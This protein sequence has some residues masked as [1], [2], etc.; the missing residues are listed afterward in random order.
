MPG[1]TS[2][3]P[4][5][6]STRSSQERNSQRTS[7]PARTSQTEGE[8]PAHEGP[9]GFRLDPAPLTRPQDTEHEETQAGRRENRADEIESW[10]LLHGRIGDL[11]REEQDHG[12]DQHLSGEDPAP[13][14]VRRAETAD[15]RPDGDGDR[16]C[17]RH[18][19]VGGG[20][21][22]S[23]EVPGHKGDDGGHDQRG[24]HALEKRPAEQEHG[25]ARRDR[26]RER[27]ASVD[28]AADREGP[29]PADQRPDLGARDHEGGHHERVGGDR[30]LDSRD[31]RADV[32]CHGGDRD[33]HDRAV[34]RHQEL[35]RRERQQDEHAPRRRGGS[36]GNRAHGV[37]A[38]AQDD[39]TSPPPSSAIRG[40]KRTNAGCDATLP[41]TSASPGG[42]APA[43]STS[44]PGAN[45]IVSAR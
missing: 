14:E 19:P 45:D 29:L 21:A 30:A 32:L 3:S 15:E 2:G 27:P 38:S 42:N 33:V 31:G 20:P 9:P 23:R 36:G 22:F 7:K 40:P 43:R 17:S 10:A 25:K 37:P 16:A 4:P 28:D 11:A 26:G 6:A 12:D 39:G 8:S 41:T 24:S 18:H 35:P 5:R 13:G 44:A 34:E 1:G